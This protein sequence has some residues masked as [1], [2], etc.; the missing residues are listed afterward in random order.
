MKAKEHIRAGSF[1]WAVVREALRRAMPPM[2]KPSGKAGLSG[3]YRDVE[4]SILLNDVFG[5]EILRTHKGRGW[6]FYNRINDE[7]V[8]LSGQVLTDTSDYSGPGENTGTPAE[9]SG[10]FEQNDYTMFFLR[11]VSAFEE[12]VGLGKY[13]LA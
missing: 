2:E 13:K 10:Y 9:T 1:D 8:D 7:C 11:F 5:G 6:H 12:T 3:K 4:I